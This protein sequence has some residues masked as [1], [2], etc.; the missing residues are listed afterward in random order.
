MVPVTNNDL[1]AAVRRVCEANGRLSSLDDIRLR[2][3]EMGETASANAMLPQLERLRGDLDYHKDILVA[4]QARLSFHSPR[5]SELPVI[6]SPAADL[7][8]LASPA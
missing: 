7:Q 4:V 2:L 8:Q 5:P 6:S 1:W 3:I